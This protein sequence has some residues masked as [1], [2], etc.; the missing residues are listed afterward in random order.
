MT[1]IS[2]R[3]SDMR[4]E[5]VAAVLIVKNEEEN[6][7]KCLESISWVD[8]IV[9]MDAGSM[10]Q[11][12]KIAQDSGARVFSN[13]NWQGFGKQRQ[14]AQ[15]HVDSDWMFMID[16]DE[17]AT[18]GLRRSIE[19]VL[20]NPS[21]D[22]VYTFNRRNFFCGKFMRHSGWYP[23]RVARLYFRQRFSYDDTVIHEKLICPDARLVHLEGNL[24][25]YTAVSYRS[26]LFKSI[27]YGDEWALHQVTLG[28]RTSLVA[29]VLHALSS[30]FRHY[31]AKLGFMDGRHGLLLALGAS[32]YAFNK[33]ASLW[34]YQ[35]PQPPD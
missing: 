25:H 9:V 14:L 20:T 28:H 19:A 6:L 29:A 30:F 22:V 7:K 13:T 35:Q 27:R 10:D 4:R 32:H 26:Y 17:R 2:K 24:E 33:Y 1:A 18:T 11:T 23:D 31:I 15:A 16:A 12:V 5:S 34:V 3:K 21:P 8:E